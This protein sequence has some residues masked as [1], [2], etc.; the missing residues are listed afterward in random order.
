VSRGTAI[1]WAFSQ[2]VWAQLTIARATSGVRRGKACRAR[3]RRPAAARR[4]RGRACT[5]Y[6]PAGQ[7]TRALATLGVHVTPFS[8]RIGRR[9]LTPGS[10]IATVIAIN[11]QGLPSAARVTKFTLLQAGAK[12]R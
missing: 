8:G 11:A 1:R 5:Y 2:P 9:A 6:V 3:P 12:R 4:N 10:Y 7:L